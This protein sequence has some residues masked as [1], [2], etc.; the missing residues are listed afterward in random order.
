VSAA[1][2]RLMLVD[3]HVMVAESLR[4]ILEQEDDI[5]VVA[6]AGTVADA[7]ERVAVVK[8]G[9]IL[10][11]YYLPDGDGVSAAMR[12]KV[13]HP[14]V[15]VLLLT[16]SDDPHALQRALDAGCVGFL[17]KV[18]PLDELPA[19][20]RLAA[21]GHVVVS[22][23]DLRQLVPAAQGGD[24]T[25]LTKREREILHLMGEG[26]TNQGIADRLVLSVHTV[27]THVQAILTKLGAH[28]KLEAV[29][30]A[31]RRRLLQ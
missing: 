2:I 28:S 27:R 8:P 12:I 21:A 19:A 1:P 14:G 5:E 4:I 18:G 7:V 9:V 16:G 15:K 24:A 23:E 30:I 3:D 10:M 11:D 26:L 22:A 31:K 20:V 29:A 13:D 6:V 25:A 17:D